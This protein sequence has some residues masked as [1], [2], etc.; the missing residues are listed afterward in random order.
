MPLQLQLPEIV[1]RGE[2]VARVIQEDL[3]HLLGQNN[4][5][6]AAS[7]L[8]DA[9]DAADDGPQCIHLDFVLDADDTAGRFTVVFAEQAADKDG[10]PVSNPHYSMYLYPGAVGVPS[11]PVRNPKHL[12]FH[13]FCVHIPLLT[14]QARTRSWSRL[15]ATTCGARRMA[16]STVR[17]NET[18]C[19]AW[20]CRLRRLCA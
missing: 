16:S 12:E 19:S 18:G 13:S 2:E 5:I 6:V 1:R 10:N 11:G 14:H 15:R 3:G 17:R 9:E 7:L 4:I 8:I 20:T